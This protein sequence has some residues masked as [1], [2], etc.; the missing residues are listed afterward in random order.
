MVTQNVNS[1]SP[2]LSIDKEKTCDIMH[3]MPWGDPSSGGLKRGQSLQITDGMK[4]FIS[5]HYLQ[6]IILLYIIWGRGVTE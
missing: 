3:A 6:H 5:Q 4:Q 1:E 2:K